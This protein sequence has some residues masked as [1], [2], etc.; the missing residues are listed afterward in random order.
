M[1]K[2]IPYIVILTI[3]VISF[4]LIQNY[5][6]TKYPNEYYNVYID[7]K[8][9][10]T[11]KSEK[12][13]DDYIDKVTSHYINVETKEDKYYI[14]EDGKIKEET[15]N[16]ISSNKKE[17]LSYGEDENGKYVILTTEKENT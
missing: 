9:I 2:Y 13:L 7:E 15:A 6:K 5:G 12:E 3:T 10:G 8:L 17:N 4:F 11:I 14:Y 16:I 1:K